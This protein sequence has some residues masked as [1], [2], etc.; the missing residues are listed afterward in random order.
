MDG[1][2]KICYFQITELL[3]AATRVR[4][5][6]ECFLHRFLKILGANSVK[7]IL[8]SLLILVFAII[9]IK[10]KYKQRRRAIAALLYVPQGLTVY[11]MQCWILDILKLSGS[12]LKQKS[13]IRKCMF[14]KLRKGICVL[15]GDIGILTNYVLLFLNTGYIDILELRHKK[16]RKDRITNDYKKI[17]TDKK[18]LYEAK[19]YL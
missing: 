1:L 19:V 6:N 2:E 15:C 8:R 12:C 17:E 11:L 13:Q 7:I 18:I 3:N 10:K 5:L 9:G 16:R 4:Y 14:L